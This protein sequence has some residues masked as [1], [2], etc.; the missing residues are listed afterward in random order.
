MPE[1]PEV[2]TVRRGLEPALVGARIEAVE[3]RRPDLRFPFP[4]NFAERLTGREVTGLGRRAKYLLADLSSGEVLVMHLGMTGRFLVTQGRSHA[5]ARRFLP[6]GG[7]ARAPTTTWFCA[8]RTAPPSLIMTRAASASWT[9]FPATRST[10]RAISPA[11]ESSRSATSFRASDRAAVPR[12]AHAAQGGAA[13]PAPHRRP[14]NIY[15]S[16]ALF[17]ANLHPENPR[18]GR[19][20]ENRPADTCAHRL[21]QT[22]REVLLEAVAAG[23]RPCAISRRPTGRSA[24]SR[25]PFGCTT[26]RASPASRRAAA[27]PSARLSQAGPLEL[28]CPSCQ[29]RNG[30]RTRSGERKA[31]AAL[32]S[33]AALSSHGPDRPHADRGC[34]WPTKLSWL[35]PA[36]RSGSSPST[37]PGAERAERHAGAELNQA[38]DGFEADPGIGCVVITGS[39]KAFAAGADIKEMQ[40]K[41]PASYLEDFITSWDRVAARRKPIIAAV[42]GLRSAAAASSP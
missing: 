5:R 3:Q 12:Q 2:E 11:W 42:A 34:P 17:R 36:A 19:R 29:R 28:L 20:D 41:T 33:G 1:L 22:I 16:E 21:A 24:N 25:T 13:R 23:A 18:W 7:R 32:P 31:L 4:Q 10:P 39:D 27:Q 9:S 37:A 40:D 26:A 15:V 30:A 14:G 6:G 38:L 8:S 35:K